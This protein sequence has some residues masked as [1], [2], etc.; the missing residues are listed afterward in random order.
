[1]LDLVHVRSFVAVA[2]ERHFG[3]AAAKLSLSQPPL[4]RH[5]MLLEGRLGVRLFYR[6]R[7]GVTLTPAGQTFLTEARRL[8]NQ[9]QA[10]ELSVRA[11]TE[12]P[13]GTIRLGFYGAAAFRLLP[14]VILAVRDRY[15]RIRLDLKELDAA[16]QREAFAF[17][18]LDMG[19][20]RPSPQP[21][22]LRTDIVLRER[23]VVAMPANHPLARRRTVRLAQ[24]DGLPFIGYSTDA[25]Y[26]HDLIRRTLSAH[27]V[28]PDVVQG[29]AQARAILSLVG[30]G[31]GVAIL[32]AH[33]RF[34]GGDGVVFRPLAPAPDMALTHLIGIEDPGRPILTLVRDVVRDVG[35]ALEQDGDPPP[36]LHRGTV[37]LHLPHSGSKGRPRA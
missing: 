9:A 23:L 31:L 6:A 4:S 14:R 3:R 12:E 27:A 15:P 37:P 1:M 18:R 7:T 34:A 21:D 10:A 19:L 29:M 35:R 17:G 20:V 28:A 5:I 26:M 30:V 22:G 25:P 2:T 32:P 36:A 33:A 24:I 8:L 13:E 16:G 11:R